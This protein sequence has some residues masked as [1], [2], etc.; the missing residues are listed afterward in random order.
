MIQCDSSSSSCYKS[1]LNLVQNWE[2]YLVTVGSSSM[3]KSF[4]DNAMKHDSI[5][6][7]SSV[8]DYFSHFNEFSVSSTE[9]VKRGK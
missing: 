9:T 3:L 1:F 6:T 2:L 4:L 5:M 7:F 8:S